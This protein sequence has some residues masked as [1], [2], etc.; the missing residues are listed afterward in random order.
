M[1]QSLAKD[2]V[3]PKV[4]EVSVQAGQI[5]VASPLLFASAH[6]GTLFTLIERLFR[7]NLARAVSLDRAQ[8]TVKIEYDNAVIDS[9]AALLNFSESLN[10]VD[11]L[12]HTSL[13]RQYL[14]RVPGR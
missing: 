13:V 8:S 4:V 2:A 3:A 14:E 11:D 9:R 12:R 1:T 5:Q 6:D 7:S 10:S